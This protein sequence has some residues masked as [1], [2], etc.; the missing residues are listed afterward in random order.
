MKSFTY[1][2]TETEHHCSLVYLKISVSRAVFSEDLGAVT[3]L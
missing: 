3:D 2:V 1:L